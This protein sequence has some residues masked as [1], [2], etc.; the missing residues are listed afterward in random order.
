MPAAFHDESFG[1]MRVH[2]VEIRPGFVELV[3]DR[4]AYDAV[5]PRGTGER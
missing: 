1:L 5:L 4:F 3:C 2:T